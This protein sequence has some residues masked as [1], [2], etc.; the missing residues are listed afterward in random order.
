M[1]I[2]HE[3]LSEL[4]VATGAAVIAAAAGASVST[5]VVPASS[6]VS[7]LVEHVVARV[8]GEPGRQG[9]HED[10]QDASGQERG[11]DVQLQLGR[12]VEGNQPSED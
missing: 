1:V 5:H 6:A 8:D 2:G 7:S 3:R 9:Q 10:R 11:Q 4:G 12:Q